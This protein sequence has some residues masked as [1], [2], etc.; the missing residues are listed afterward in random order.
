MN[1]IQTVH[2]LLIDNCTRR[3][4]DELLSSKQ[5]QSYTSALK[6]ILAA[7]QLRHR[8]E[9]EV[10]QLGWDKPFFANMKASSAE[11]SVKHAREKGVFNN[12]SAVAST[13]FMNGDDIGYIVRDAIACKYLIGPCSVP[14]R[15]KRVQ[16]YA[17]AVPSITAAV[18]QFYCDWVDKRVD[19]N[20]LQERAVSI[21][22]DIGGGGGTIG[23]V[24]GFGFTT[25]CHLLADLGLPLFKPDIWVCR[26]VSSL[27][28]VRAAIQKAWKLHPDEPIPFDFLQ[29]KL[30]GTGAPKAYRRIVQPVMNALVEEVR[31]LRFD[32]F[33]LEPAF[34]RARF[35]DWTV[36][37]FAVSAA[38]ESYG[39]ERRPIDV[40]RAANDQPDELVA[41]AQ[42]LNAAQV[43]H[44]A[45]AALEKAERNLAKA[46]DC[47]A[48]RRPDL[49]RAKRRLEQLCTSVAQ[50]KRD[51]LAE[52]AQKAWTSYK[53]KAKQARWI[54][55][56]H[57]PNHTT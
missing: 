30:V 13:D 18:N 10:W 42:W 15:L 27:P 46:R 47:H 52:Q 29:S 40:L 43:S 26:I 51:Q 39:L 55:T 45:K 31:L 57:Y 44:D 25:A 53:C 6:R 33:D 48:K 1:F 34:L 9:E 28:G 24:T 5:R 2:S 11:P 56:A 4:D 35:V 32:E 54:V 14:D 17:K 49:N 36:V 12:R 19:V 16:A 20:N 22:E 41:L 3:V 38:T 8:T 7:S 50:A 37:H 23:K 21:A